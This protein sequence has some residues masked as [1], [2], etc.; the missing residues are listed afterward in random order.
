[1]SNKHTALFIS[2]DGLTDPLGQ[3]QILPYLAG[4]SAKGHKILILSA[5]K[6]DHYKSR[7]A[8]INNIVQKNNIIWHSV[9]YT[10]KPPVLS[11][12]YDMFRLYRVAKRLIQQEKVTLIHCRSYLSAYLGEKLSQK[13][14]LPWIFDM[15]GFWADER[16][17]GNIWNLKNPVYATIYTW[18]KNKEKQ[19]IQ[20]ATQTVVLTYAAKQEIDSW[21]V[22]S[23][24]PIQVIPCC[25]DTKL[26]TPVTPPL[27]DTTPP[28]PLTI[29]YL[30]SIGTWYLSDE[31]L[32]FFK[33]LLKKYPNAQ[34]RWITP[35]NHSLLIE[36]I[37]KIGLSRDHFLIK[38]AERSAV[39]TEIAQADICIFFIRPAYSKIGSSATKMG[40][41]LAMG[42][43]II[44]N[45][46]VG[47]HDYLFANYP[48][49]LLLPELSPNSYEHAV[50]QIPG[51]LNINSDRLR[52]V[53]L[54]YFSLEKGVELYNQ[55]YQNI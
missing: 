15:R 1:M 55:L 34:F 29:L 11:T 45:A 53:A 22:P 41:I 2:Y 47:D 4:L 10:K 43:A 35:D 49:G 6:K 9:S 24:A 8:T 33:H 32:L 19:W 13:F 44:A 51:L 48:C 7:Y 31:M 36:K 30:G 50:S 54:D 17:D 27:N 21:Q 23:A 16:I 20:N 18:F 25:V 42:K 52:A 3:S 26:F 37:N 5:E 40:E 28:K 39:P 14:K 46:H 38:S 12:V